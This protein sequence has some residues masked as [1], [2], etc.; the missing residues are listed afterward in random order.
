MSLLGV[1]QW[2]GRYAAVWFVAVGGVL[3]LCL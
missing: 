1:V 2:V 3:G